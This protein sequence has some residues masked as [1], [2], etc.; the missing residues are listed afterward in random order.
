LGFSRILDPAGAA[1]YESGFLKLKN[2][3]TTTIT[4]S[5]I[6]ISDPTLW[7]LN[8]DVNFPLTIAAGEEKLVRVNFIASEGDRGS[9]KA[10]LTINSDDAGFETHVVTLGYVQKRSGFD[11]KMNRV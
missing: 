4:V 9:R 11:F 10:T 2:F 1:A 5:S 3:G 7:A 8:N 6:D